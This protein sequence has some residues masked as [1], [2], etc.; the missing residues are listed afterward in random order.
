[1][2]FGWSAAELIR[3][4]QSI[5]GLKRTFPRDSIYMDDLR[6]ELEAFR[7]TLIRLSGVKSQEVGMDHLNKMFEE[8][9]EYLHDIFTELHGFLQKN[10]AFNIRGNKSRWLKVY[11]E[12]IRRITSRLCATRMKLE[13]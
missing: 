11:E 1:M 6:Q 9:L 13:M 5:F 4:V 12:P 7:S 8:G 3:V 10:K 2:S